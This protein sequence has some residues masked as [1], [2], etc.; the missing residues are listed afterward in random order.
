MAAQLIGASWSPGDIHRVR[1][2]GSHP[3]VTL[4]V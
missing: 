3:A 4:H 1:H 2:T